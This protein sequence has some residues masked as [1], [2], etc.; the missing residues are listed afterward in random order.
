[1]IDFSTRGIRNNNPFNIKKSNNTWIGQVGF[2]SGN[3]LK[4]ANME[5]GIRAGI[6]ILRTYIKK[7]H[8]DTPE[9]II[10]RFSPDGH[11]KEYVSYLN[12]RLKCNGVNPALPI[13]YRSFAF[14]QLVRAMMWYESNFEYSELD[15]KSLIAKY[16][17]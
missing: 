8:R 17:L 11:E 9:K 4:F 14:R 6:I 16:K 12:A 7:Y 1:M 3:F 2:D 13:A 5:F 15:V 10:E